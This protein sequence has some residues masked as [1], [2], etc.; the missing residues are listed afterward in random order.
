[1]VF[2]LDVNYPGTKVVINLP[3]IEEKDRLALEL[4]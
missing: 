3:L 4:K 2:T 1:M